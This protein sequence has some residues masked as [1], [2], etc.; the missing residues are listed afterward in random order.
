[1]TGDEREPISLFL[2]W[3]R[4]AREGG[5]GASGPVVRR[6]LRWL[7]ALIFGGELPEEGAAAL[8]TATP[9]GRPSLR[10]V[11]VKRVDEEGL[12][13]HTSYL[14]RKGEELEANPRAALLF[15]WP[16]PP[17][18]VRVEGAVVRLSGAESDAY[19]RTRR[20]G[21]QLA[22]VASEQSAPIADRATLLARVEQLRRAHAGRDVPRP[23]T[24]GGYRLVPDS[25]E[26]WEGRADRLH[27]RTRYWRAA[28]GDPWR[29]ELLQP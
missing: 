26:F 15:H 2:A 13:F 5:P 17:R 16:W 11:L 21:S 12:V 3:R 27:E 6:V 28:P 18:Q 14:S 29:S 4:E 25:V 22:A 10:M 24:W 8:A 20:R 19:W 1:M 9:D 7:A 23:P